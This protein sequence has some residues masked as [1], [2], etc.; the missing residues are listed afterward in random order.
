MK[1]NPIRALMLAFAM[2]MSGLAFAAPASANST[3]TYAAS[4]ATALVGNDDQTA[5]VATSADPC[6]FARTASRAERF[7]GQ[8]QVINGV[9]LTPEQWLRLKKD[10]ILVISTFQQERLDAA[11]AKYG[12]RSNQVRKMM[13]KISGEGNI[14]MHFE[15]TAEGVMRVQN[16]KGIDVSQNLLR[17][18]VWSLADNSNGVPMVD[19]YF[20]NEN[21]QSIFSKVA[22]QTVG[23]VVTAGAN[24]GFGKLLSTTCKGPCKGNGGT[25]VT[26]NA[27]ATGGDGGHAYAEGG[28]AAAGAQSSSTL[29]QTGTGGTCSTCTA[30]APTNPNHTQNGPQGP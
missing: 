12:W 10:G 5:L 1:C 30:P 16:I 24:Q 21:W 14:I 18:T 8:C 9:S 27:S 7:L 25:V 6:S 22:A 23:G 13:D 17:V 19:Q 3:N 29:N 15:L 2:L 20:A 28:D 4:A 11:A 26:V